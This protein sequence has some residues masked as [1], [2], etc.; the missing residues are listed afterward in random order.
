MGDPLTYPASAHSSSYNKGIGH[1]TK[2]EACGE[3]ELCC[4]QC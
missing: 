4:I 3:E 1:E 2:L